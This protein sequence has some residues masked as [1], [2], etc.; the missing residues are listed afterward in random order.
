MSVENMDS[1]EKLIENMESDEKIH[2][3]IE[4]RCCVCFQRKPRYKCP[5]CLRR[6]CSLPCVKQ[7]KID[8]NCSGKFIEKI[9][10]IRLFGLFS[11]F[12]TFSDLF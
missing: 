5:A 6:T 12:L 7:H 2:E 11:R 9:G 10:I 8:F 1:D 3:K 4:E